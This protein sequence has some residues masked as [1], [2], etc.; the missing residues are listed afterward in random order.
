[1]VKLSNQERLKPWMGVILFVIGVVYLI[2]PGSLMQMRWGMTGL[3]TSELGFVIIAVL[4]CVIRKVSLKEV[5]PVQKVTAADIFGVFFMFLGAFM[6]NLI[7]VGFSMLFLDLIGLGNGLEEAAQLTEFLY[8]NKTLYIVILLVVAVVGP[9]CE[10]L[11]MRGAVLSNFRSIGKD[12]VIVLI[13]GA[14]FGILHLS[15]LR[16]LNTACFGAVLAYVMVK[17]NNII[18]PILLHFLNNFVSSVVGL[19]G[20]EGSTDAAMASFEGLNYTSLLGSYMMIGFLAPIFFVLGAMLL[21]REH[22]RPRRFLFAGII[23]AALLFGGIGITTISTAST[24]LTGDTIL[25]WN[26]STIV[27]EEDARNK[28]LAEACIELD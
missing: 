16:F 21:D 19:F 26:N 13:S 17:K 3:V 25:T 20:G 27:T 8:G 4:Y 14:M 9:I 6:V 7:T 24:A 12:W 11:F 28:N 1:M 15:S 5:F 18:L 10:E 2:F 23:S 22:H